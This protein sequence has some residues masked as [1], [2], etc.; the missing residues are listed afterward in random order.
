MK[1]LTSLITLSLMTISC[2]HAQ[3]ENPVK[4]TYTAVKKADKTYQ[5]TFEATISG[6]WHLYSQNTPAGGP[7]PTSFTF[8]KN[9]LVT[10]KGQV[11][12]NGKIITKHEKVFDLDVKYYSGKVVFTQDIVLKSAVKTNVSGEIEFMVC[13]DERCLAPQT[14]SF[15]I[16]VQ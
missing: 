5:L 8:K 10:L 13:N 3:V 11:V 7:V 2:I 4:W 14:V 12:E 15:D 16:K 9:P 6:N 1:F